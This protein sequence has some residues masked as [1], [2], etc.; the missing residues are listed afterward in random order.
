MKKAKLAGERFVTDLC[1]L[2]LTRERIE[3]VPAGEIFTDI[4]CG[5]CQIA[6]R[7]GGKQLLL[8]SYVEPLPRVGVGSCLT[9]R[10]LE[11]TAFILARMDAFSAAF[12]QKEQGN[13]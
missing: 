9:Q 3:P 12:V 13:K 11:H 2:C 7:K 10:L 8:R 1:G 6:D 5:V 4:G